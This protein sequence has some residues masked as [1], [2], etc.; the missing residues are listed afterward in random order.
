LNEQLIADL[1]I[2]VLIGQSDD[3]GDKKDESNGTIGYSVNYHDSGKPAWITFIPDDVTG[4]FLFN[5][6]KRNYPI[7]RTTYWI[8]NRPFPN[9]LHGYHMY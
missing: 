7:I 2:S 5:L 6:F 9:L 4:N 1:G 8:L 3:A